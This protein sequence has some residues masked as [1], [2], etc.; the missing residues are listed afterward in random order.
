MSFGL[1]DDSPIKIKCG[2]NKALLLRKEYTTHRSQF[3]QFEDMLLTPR[4][5]VGESTHSK[6][7]NWKDS[8]LVSGRRI[9]DL[10]KEGQ[11]RHDGECNCNWCKLCGSLSSYGFRAQRHHTNDQAARDVDRETESVDSP[12]HFG[13]PLRNVH[14]RK[15][16]KKGKA[17]SPTK[18]HKQVSRSGGQEAQG[19][20]VTCCK[21]IMFDIH[22][23]DGKMGCWM[24]G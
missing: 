7:R 4:E 9:S 11:L 24:Y 22:R 15:R 12:Y 8:F 19:D 21:A 16:K 10:M 3:I 17:P 20:S 14:N 23:M 1:S 18:Q 6:T 2:K 5:F 13:D